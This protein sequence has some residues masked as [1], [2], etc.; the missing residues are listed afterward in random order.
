M[1]IGVGV[2]TEPKQE[3]R[4]SNGSLFTNPLLFVINGISG[5]ALEKRLYIGT[6]D[7]VNAYLGPD[8]TLA[9]SGIEISIDDGSGIAAGTTYGWNWK[10]RA[11]DK[12]PTEAEW[13]AISPAANINVPPLY[14]LFNDGDG[15]LMSYHPFWIRIEVPA[16]AH[17]KMSTQTKLKITATR[18]DVGW[19]TD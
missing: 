7:E 1:A 5:G 14:N 4:I 13:A 8:G 16:L 11:G 10:M 9:G 17:M 12:Q 18:M 19:Y 3:A 15:G 2:Y 6:N